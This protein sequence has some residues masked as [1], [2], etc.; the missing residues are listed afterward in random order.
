IAKLNES[1]GDS[2]TLKQVKI[3]KQRIR[4]LR[5]RHSSIFMLNI[6][7]S[8]NIDFS[9]LESFIK[10]SMELAM[11]ER[12]LSRLQQDLPPM[13]KALME[14]VDALYTVDEKG[15]E[16]IRA[17]HKEKVISDALAK[18]KEARLYANKTDS[19]IRNDLEKSYNAIYKINRPTE[20]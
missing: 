5:N 7:D 9:D 16:R 18:I 3:L 20:E 17:N 15:T 19:E 6:E 12:K 8:V 13:D 4:T 14:E 1:R 11:L 2:E 10:D